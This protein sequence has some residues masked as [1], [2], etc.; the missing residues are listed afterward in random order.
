MRIF[1]HHN[2]ECTCEHSKNENVECTC[3]PKDDKEKK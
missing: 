2:P 1:T 3:Q